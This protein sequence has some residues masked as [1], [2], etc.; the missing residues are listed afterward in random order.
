MMYAPHKLTDFE[1]D[2][3]LLPSLIRSK[4]AID[5]IKELLT[6]KG[7]VIA[8]NYGHEIYRCPKCANSMDVS[9]FTWIITAQF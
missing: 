3:P 4:K 7:A 5:F 1:A 9:S 8:D 6:D 2:N